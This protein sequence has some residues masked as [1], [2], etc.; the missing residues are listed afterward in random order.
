MGPDAKV[1]T[2]GIYGKCPSISDCPTDCG[3][4]RYHNNGKW[5]V[6]ATIVVECID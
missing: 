1:D 6:D 5:K 3:S 2:G 4:W